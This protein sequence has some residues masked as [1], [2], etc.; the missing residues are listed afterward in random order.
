[1]SLARRS[2]GA[3]QKAQETAAEYVP[4]L[5]LE[6]VR[7]LAEAARRTA[8]PSRA[9]RDEVLIQ[10]LFDGSLRGSEALGLAPSDLRQTADG[11][12]AWV[13]GKGGKYREVA[14][15]PGLVAKLHSYAYRKEIGPAEP[16]FQGSTSGRQLGRTQAWRICQRAFQ[17]AGLTKPAHVGAM[18]VLRHSGLIY[19]LEQTGNPKSVQ[20]QAG[21]VSAKMTLRYMKTVQAKHSLKIQQGVQIPW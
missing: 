19:R 12:S 17:V 7:L 5:G 13:H 2:I 11:W 16:I 20:D 10:T 3:I 8:R 9:D 6:E 14:I 4:H 1:M 18:H 15:T 21:H